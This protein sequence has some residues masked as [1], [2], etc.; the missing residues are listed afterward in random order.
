MM[1]KVK[2][3]GIIQRIVV[4]AEIADEIEWLNEQGVRT[5]GS[6]SGH[7]EELPT[8]MITPSS[9]ERAR[10]LGYMPRMKNNGLFEM[11]LLGLKGERK[12]DYLERARKCLNHPDRI[13]PET[14]VAYALL[15][16]AESL[17]TIAGETL[18]PTGLDEL[19]I[20]RI[21]EWIRDHANHS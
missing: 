21:G 1:G 13:P 4:D 2:E 10:K 3:I 17:R 5:E 19:D 9:V 7:G 8:A 20:Q 14:V 18:V 15:D 12:T 16:I 11:T 6:C